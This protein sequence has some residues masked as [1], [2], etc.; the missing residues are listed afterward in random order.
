MRSLALALLLALAIPAALTFAQSNTSSNVPN[1]SAATAASAHHHL[2]APKV[3]YED[4]N[5]G[6]CYT[7]RTYYFE[8]QDGD[9]PRPAGMTTCTRVSQRDL[10]RA[11]R[12]HT[13][14]LIPATR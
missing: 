9:A 7:M 3:R 10:K 5:D 14:R 4:E 11:D 1:Q 8:R 6:V 2:L 13:P 12:D